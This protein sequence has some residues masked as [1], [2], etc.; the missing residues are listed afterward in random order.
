MNDKK[1][2]SPLIIGIGIAAFVL[3]GLPCIFGV[4]MC[5]G[6]FVSSHEPPQPA[7]VPA[8]PSVNESGPKAPTE[9]SPPASK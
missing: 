2:G 7:G 9:E 3:L 1:S 4:L 5:A 8:P 6:V